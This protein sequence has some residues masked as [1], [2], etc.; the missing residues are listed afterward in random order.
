MNLK[1]YKHLIQLWSK[2]HFE[3][4]STQNY[5]VF[6][7][8]NRYFKR[9]VG[10][11]SGE[12]TYFWKSKGFSE[13]RINSIT[14][15][16][17]SITPKLSYYG[18]KIRPKFNGSCLKHDKVTYTHGKTENIYIIFETNEKYNISIY[19]TLKNCLFGSIKLP[20]TPDKYKYSGFGIGFDRKGKFSMAN[21]FGQNCIIFG[22]DMSSSV[23]VDNKKKDIPTPGLDG[24]TLTVVTKYSINF[25]KNNKVEQTE[26]IAIYLLMVPKLLNL[27]QKILKL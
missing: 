26:Q 7:P 9:I 22:V 10:V 1:N 21:G 15:S 17:Y 18:N 19:P 27:K 24:T 20:K 2:S 5:F 16:N 12:Y 23:H 25:I 4:D 3:E 6:H 8:I 13:E 14:A 11:A